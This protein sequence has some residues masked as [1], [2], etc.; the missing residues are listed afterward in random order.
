MMAASQEPVQR[1]GGASLHP[2]R[3][4]LLGVGMLAGDEI[5]ASTAWAKDLTAVSGPRAT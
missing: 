4:M 2:R 3:A 5:Y 1:S